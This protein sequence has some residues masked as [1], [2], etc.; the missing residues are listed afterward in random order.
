MQFRVDEAIDILRATPAAIRAFLQ[1][2]S[3]R[4]VYNNYGENTFSPFDVVGHLIHGERNDWMARTRVIL[5]HGE[6]RPFEPF[7]RYAMYQ[8]SKGKSLDELL[9]TFHSLR[10]QNVKALEELR[11]TEEHLALRGTHPALG[12]VTLENLL[13]CWVVHDLN[14][15]AQ[16]AKAMAYQYR[17]SVG[18]WQV[19]MSVLR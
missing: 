9:D 3:E 5:E 16:C 11:L 12:S 19:H 10:M 6:A 7:D 18:P 8:A 14:H 4:W 17:N 13:A 15:I 1:D 2:V